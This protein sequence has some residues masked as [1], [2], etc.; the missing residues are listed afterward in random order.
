[1]VECAGTLGVRLVAVVFKAQF[2]VFQH[3]AALR[4]RDVQ[5]RRS[6]RGLHDVAKGGIV[7][8]GL[9]VADSLFRVRWGVECGRRE[10]EAHDV[11]VLIL[12]N[13]E[14]ETALEGMACNHLRMREVLNA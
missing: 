2:E 3:L 6:E 12:A 11:G 4:V 13:R 7:G 10:I 1:M 9:N 5:H 14:N 8:H